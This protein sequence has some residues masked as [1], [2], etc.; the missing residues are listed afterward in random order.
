MKTSNNVYSM[1]AFDLAVDFL[2]PE[3]KIMNGNSTSGSIN[4]IARPEQIKMIA[5]KYFMIEELNENQIEALD[6]VKSVY[7]LLLDNGHF[8]FGSKTFTV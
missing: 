5:V 4:Y 8:I 1:G 3:I 7:K 6:V 2:M